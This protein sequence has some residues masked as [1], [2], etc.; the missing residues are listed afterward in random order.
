MGVVERPILFAR[1]MVRAILNGR[2]TQT[3]R[4]FKRHQIPSSENFDGRFPEMRF[5][6]IANNHPRWGFCAF[7]ETE[8]KCAAQLI[9]Y[10]AC[11]FG[12]KGDRLWVRE[13]WADL[14]GMGFDAPVAYGAD[15]LPGTDGDMARIAYGVKWRP[16]IHMPRWAS[17]TTLEIT[18][19]RAERLQEMSNSD[20]L[21]E[22]IEAGSPTYP[23]LESCPRNVREQFQYLWESINGDSSWHQN[24]W[25][26]VI[27]FKRIKP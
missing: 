6:A 14:R 24:P 8:A 25:V 1:E 22:G 10:G 3:R 11:P 19:V 21:E 27:E 7:G 13:T 18:D 26:W 23:H 5:S 15:T 16:S 20:C 17:R 12:S 4:I 9:E 2:K